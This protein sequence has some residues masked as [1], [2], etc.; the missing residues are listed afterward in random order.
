MKNLIS[1]LCLFVIMTSCEKVID[2]NLNDTAPQYVIESMLLAGSNDFEVRISRTTSYFDSSAPAWVSDAVV[3]L[4]SE[5]GE[6]YEL[7][8][9]QNGLYVH[10]DLD[11]VEGQTYT[12]EVTVAGSTYT[13]SNTIPQ[14][15]PISELSYV[16]NDVVMTIQD[17]VETENFYWI[18]N[19]VNEID[20]EE[21]NRRRDFIDDFANNGSLISYNFYGSFDEGEE[22]DDFGPSLESGDI[23]YVELRSIDAQTNTYFSTLDDILESDGPFATSPANPVTNWSN[24]ALGYFGAGYSD[25]GMI[26]IP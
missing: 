7:Q 3:L 8:L 4:T 15:V 21:Y 19:A 14:F 23:V 16:D 1:I 12:L 17:P 9:T 11:P 22:E 6:L 13:A 18:Y 20:E 10:N 5:N 25:F 24:G 2:V 26:T